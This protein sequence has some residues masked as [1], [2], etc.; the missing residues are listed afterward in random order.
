MFKKLV[1]VSA[2]AASSL[3]AAGNNLYEITPTIGGTIHLDSDKYKDDIDLS[4]GIRFANRVTEHALVEVGYDRIDGA[5]YSQSKEDT[6]IA[7][8]FADVVYEYGDS[9]TFV[10][11]AL[12]G[13]GYEDVQ[14]ERQSL[15]SAGFGQWGV[16]VRYAMTE[17][18]HLKAEA[19]HLIS[20]DGRSDALV[21]LGFA[22]PFGTFAKEAPKPVVA[23]VVAPKAEPVK[24]PLDSDGDGVYDDKDLCPGTPKNFKVDKDGCPI[25]YTFL[26][27]FPFDSAEITSEY[28]GEV[29][30]FAT[31]LENHKGVSANLEGHT[32]SKGSD[33]YN[34]KLSAKR[35]GAVKDALIKL[36]VD[37][38]RLSSVGFGEERPIADN[39]TDAGRQ[40]N[41]R[42]EAI[43]SPLKR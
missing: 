16:G 25:Q 29:K 19:R 7:R 2:V 6:D 23:P 13:F 37:K 38:N 1:L 22:I 15:N 41:R 12:I 18:L 31:F 5:K 32:D 40:K 17:Y 36:G 9:R 21:S 24:A 35:A 10:P 4:Y 20:F 28:M 26:V 30:D 14:N 34:K 27:Q 3:M 39:A 8:Y 42:V 11:Y 43:I 33:S